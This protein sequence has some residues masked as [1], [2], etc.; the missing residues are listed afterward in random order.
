MVIENNVLFVGEEI[1]N[2]LFIIQV[3]VSQVLLQVDQHL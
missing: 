2:K 1:C 3:P